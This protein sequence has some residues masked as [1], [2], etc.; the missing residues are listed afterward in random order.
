MGPL[1]IACTSWLCDGASCIDQWYEQLAP[2]FSKKYSSGI[3]APIALGDSKQIY[4][5]RRGLDA[6]ERTVG[7]F[8]N[9]LISENI[10]LSSRFDLIN[11]LDPE[12]CNQLPVAC[13]FGGSD[14]LL[15]QTFAPELIHNQLREQALLKLSNTGIRLVGV[16]LRV[17]AEPLFN[18]LVRQHGN[19]AS[20]LT[21]QSL[22]LAKS[23]LTRIF[24]T[25]SAALMAT[26]LDGIELFFD[27]HG[28]RS[29]YAAALS[30]CWPEWFFQVQSEERHRSC[31]CVTPSEI[32]KNVHFLANGDSLIPCGLASI[33]AK[34]TREL[35]MRRLNAFWHNHSP[36]LKPTAGY[37]AD[38]RRFAQ[39][40]ESVAATLKLERSQ[41]WRCV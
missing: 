34:W 24:T 7:F 28:G 30:A 10:L 5:S 12:F 13:W 41:W 32:P 33:F 4:N 21:D 15:G 27:K 25:E 2:E 18:E 36:G 9:R 29:K 40:I 20:L 1:V 11:S 35:L 38:A 37:P 39:D 14:S 26:P 22:R 8:S 6:L 23:M 19:K 16:Q 31:Y 17:I 3:D